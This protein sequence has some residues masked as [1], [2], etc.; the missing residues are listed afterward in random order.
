MCQAPFA[1]PMCRV[2][3]NLQPALAGGRLLQ[4]MGF[5]GI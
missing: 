3:A 5:F 1:S 2:A 4:L